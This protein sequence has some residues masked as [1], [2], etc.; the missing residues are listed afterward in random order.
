MQ[1]I[2]QIWYLT[3]SNVYG[4]IA[5]SRSHIIMSAVQGNESLQDGEELQ[6]GEDIDEK[7]D[8]K[9]LIYGKVV[10]DPESVGYDDCIGKC[11]DKEDSTDV[12]VTTISRSIAC[13]DL[14][15]NEGI[16]P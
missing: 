2:L 6:D 13:Y 16:F 15:T 3:H 12:I 8:S 11:S 14:P 10:G 9:E 1:L 7:Q 5:V 4:T